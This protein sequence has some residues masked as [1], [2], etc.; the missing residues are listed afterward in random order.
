MKRL[1]LFGLAIVLALT[2]APIGPAQAWFQGPAILGQHNVLPGETLYCIGRGYGVPPQAIAQANGLAPSARLTPGQV[3]DIPAV[4][5]AVIPAGPVCAPQFTAAGLDAATPETEQ[6]TIQPAQTVSPTLSIG[7]DGLYTIRRGD[8]LWRIARRFGVTVLALREA[9]NLRSSLIFV[10]QQLVIPGAA[11]A[12]A[13]AATLPAQVEMAAPPTSEAPAAAETPGSPATPVP[14]SPPPDATATQSPAPT[15][16]PQPTSTVPPSPTTAPGPVQPGPV[17]TLQPTNPPPPTPT[18][19]VEPTATP[20][21]A[22]DPL[23][24]AVNNIAWS[25]PGQ[26]LRGGW[27][28]AAALDCLAAASVDVIIDLRLPSEDR[29]NEPELARQAGITYVNLGVPDDTAPSPEMLAN[30]LATVNSRLAAGDLVLV[31]DAAGRGRMGFWDAVYHLDRGSS[32]QAAVEDRYLGKVLPFSGAKI[33]CDD[34]GNGQVQALALLGQIRTGS[35]Y[36]PSV[37]EYGTSWANCP[38][39]SYMAGWNYATVWP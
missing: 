25:A 4:A 3:L 7:V 29:I 22:S 21:P 2:A 20:V 14:S 6:A 33:G 31:H 26:L 28:E 5:W 35:L 9:N 38:L 13:Q 18:V 34:G 1:Y 17:P 12:A 16:A 27:P 30:W 24:C 8:T 23:Q 19:V 39:P 32:A 15:D 11:P 36:Y 10:G 37:D